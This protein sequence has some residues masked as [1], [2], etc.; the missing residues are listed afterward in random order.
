MEK[1]QSCQREEEGLEPVKYV[2]VSVRIMHGKSRH[3]FISI[4]IATGDT[5]LKIKAVFSIETE[6]I[7]PA[8]RDASLKAHSDNEENGNSNLSLGLS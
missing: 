7:S 4:K 3:W 5:S 6:Y 8:Y 1:D 2:A